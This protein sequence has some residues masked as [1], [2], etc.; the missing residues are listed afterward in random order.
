MCS[1]QV[2]EWKDGELVDTQEVADV[3]EEAAGDGDDA[4]W[5][6]E[7]EVCLSFSP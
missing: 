4:D 6:E 2:E 5:D 3:E 1:P 7:D